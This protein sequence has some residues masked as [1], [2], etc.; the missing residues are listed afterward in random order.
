MN[1]RVFA[2]V[3]LAAGCADPQPEPTVAEE[4]GPEPVAMTLW[5]DRTEL[6]VEFPPLRPG[7]TSRFAVHL[8]DL[9]SFEPLRE[10]TVEVR[11]DY[12]GDVS[13]QFVAGSPSRPG[14]FGVDVVPSRR[15]NPLATVSVRSPG[16]EDSHSLGPT[17]V[18]EG[19]SSP[20]GSSAEGGH[21]GSISFLKEQQWTLD[22]ATEVVRPVPIRD[23]LLVPA[24]VEVRSG[25]RL[26][27]TAPVAGRLLPSRRLPVLGE[28]VED[29]QELGAIVP[30]WD[31]P[32]DP[33]AVRLAVDQSRLALEAA[34]RERQRVER[35]L[36][37]GAVP[38]RRVH[39]ALAREALLSTQFD[40]ANMRMERYEVSRRDAH[41]QG[42]DT[43]F[44]VRSHLS[45]VVT[46]VLVKDGA[47]VREGEVLL[48]VA[49]TDTVHVSG[50]IPESRSEALRELAGAEIQMPGSGD[51][52]PVRQLVT[53]GRLVNP[54][55]K[56]LKATY[57]VDNRDGRLAIGQ[58]ALLRLYTSAP[59]EAPGI[60]V[61]A[62]VSD[63]GQSLAYVQTGGES[64]EERRIQLG[65]RTGQRVQVTAGLN[66]GERIVTRGAYLVRLASM[67]TE[68]PAHGHV[69]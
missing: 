44:T 60:P 58:S 59:V 31:G 51:L 69:H 52:I 46:S 15:G 20:G 2:V 48:E 37:V 57:L 66:E 41:D 11:L 3:L 25:G 28:F 36:E 42:A 55:T 54:A 8:T 50:A 45:G 1:S 67:S 24:T 47:H 12:S 18:G 38:Q 68:V 26:A 5:S 21:A 10:G 53:A 34:R 19:P 27:V 35:L 63:G 49:A 17:P 30:L 22:F 56:T 4:V 13:Q 39:D 61:D 16:I 33:V 32:R 14:I 29:E 9:K 23:S 62:V 40:A 7:E 64:F 65:S 43:A 6:F